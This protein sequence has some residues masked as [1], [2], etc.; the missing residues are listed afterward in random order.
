VLRK[1]LRKGTTVEQNLRAA[2]ICRKYGVK[3][4]ASYMMGIPGETEEEVMDTVEMIQAIQPDHHMC[5]FFTPQP[6]TYLSEVCQEQN[7]CLISE[8]SQLDRGMLS[9]KIRGVDYDFL[10]WAAEEAQDLPWAKRILRR[11][12]RQSWGRRLR[13]TLMHVPMS[14]E[15]LIRLRQFIRA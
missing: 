11:V 8:G 2:K 9:P 12:A 5:S 10:L 4:L 3:I 14:R 7:L 6:G 15:L 1:I 13:H